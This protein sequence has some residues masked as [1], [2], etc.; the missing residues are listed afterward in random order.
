MI[1]PLSLFAQRY[2]RNSRQDGPRIDTDQH[3]TAIH[4]R[5][6]DQALRMRF[7]AQRR[8]LE[9]SG[10]VVCI[11]G[12]SGGGKSTLLRTINALETVDS[13]RS[14]S[15]ASGSRGPPQR[16]A[17]RREVGMVFQNFN[18][19]PHMTVRRNV[20]LAPMRARGTSGGGE[21]ARRT[22][23]GAGGDRDQ[24]DKYPEQLSGGQ[25]QRVAIAR[26]LAM[27][28][29]VMLFDEPTSALDAEMVSEVLQVIREMVGTA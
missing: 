26:A 14:P 25:Q 20:M 4:L 7:S 10:E 29:P 2:E 6:C 15:T 8:R 27:E 13:G 18:L 19:F 17:I 23:A 12:P 22:T 5:E 21:R 1:F 11:V 24:I 3:E 28:P 16:A 9:V